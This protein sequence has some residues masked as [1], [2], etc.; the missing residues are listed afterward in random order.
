V[1]H[2]CNPQKLG[3]QKQGDLKFK[4]SLGKVSDRRIQNP[5][6]SVG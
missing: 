2:T 4:V 3:R 6:T 5:E 1:V